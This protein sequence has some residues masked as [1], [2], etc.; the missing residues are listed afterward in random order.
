MPNL[1]VPPRH[2]AGFLAVKDFTKDEFAN[3]A[4]A[5]QGDT[6]AR[7][8]PI[9]ELTRSVT[10][11]VPRLARR[12]GESIVQALLSLQTARA[13]HDNSLEEFASGIA[14]SED[15]DLA[16]EGAQTLANRIQFLASI[17]AL[18]VTAKALDVAQEHDRVF[19]RARVLTDI[20]PVFGD[21]ALDPPLGAVVTHMLRIDAFRNGQAEDYYVALDNS[22]LIALR[23]V[24]GRAVD[25]NKSLNRVLDGSGFSRFELSEESE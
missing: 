22:D 5:L 20:R 18:A 12:D 3:V 17:P 6:D 9:N 1:R 10:E 23:E 19:H 16:P 14:S 8:V 25:K 13:I 11:A 4:E 15:L 7:Y 24:V 21:S 2:R